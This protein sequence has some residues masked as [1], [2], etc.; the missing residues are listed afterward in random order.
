MCGTFASQLP[1]ARVRVLR[2]AVNNLRLRQLYPTARTLTYDSGLWTALRPCELNVNLPLDTLVEHH[3]SYR[4]RPHWL[5]STTL[6]WY[7]DYA[8]SIPLCR[9]ALSSLP[10][11]QTLCPCKSTLSCCRN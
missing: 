9:V 10:F 1:A 2:A 5:T 4:A 7:R 3:A 8:T 6:L 11:L